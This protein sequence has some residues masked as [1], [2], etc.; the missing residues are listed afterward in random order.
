MFIV[1]VKKNY[2]Y[3]VRLTIDMAFNPASGW[4]NFIQVNTNDNSKCHAG[5]KYTF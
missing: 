5:G 4:S 3:I 1:E 2:P